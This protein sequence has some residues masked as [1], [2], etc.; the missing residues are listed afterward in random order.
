MSQSE[1]RKQ[2]SELC[3]GE[4][5]DEADEEDEEG[6][7][8]DDDGEIG[9][10]NGVEGESVVEEERRREVS[11]TGVFGISRDFRNAIKR[12]FSRKK[13]RRMKEKDTT[14]SE[15]RR[16]QL[17][18]S[19]AAAAERGGRSVG[20]YVCFLQPQT[21]ECPE[22]PTSDPNSESFSFEMLRTL[23]ES[24]DFYCKESNPYI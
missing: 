5:G 4:K 16:L 11:R 3:D 21:D 14:D 8:Q 13:K 20:C 15:I 6:S 9:C 17:S 10:C 19:L 7:K 24:N 12:S 1:N 2:Q 18:S 22:T 23:I